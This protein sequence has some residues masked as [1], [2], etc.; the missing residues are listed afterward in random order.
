M[1]D[2][3]EESSEGAETGKIVFKKKVRKNLRQRRNSDDDEPNE[4][5]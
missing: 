1:S 3:K 2:H 4:E 5:P